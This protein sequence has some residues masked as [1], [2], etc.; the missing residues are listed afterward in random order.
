[1]ELLT[2]LFHE[3]PKSRIFNFHEYFNQSKI[4]LFVYLLLSFLSLIKSKFIHSIKATKIWKNIPICFDVT[5]HFQK[6]G[7]FL[8][9][10][11]CMNFKNLKKTSG[12]GIC[13]TIWWAATKQKSCC[14]ER[15]NCKYNQCNMR[16]FYESDTLDLH[17]RAVGRSGNPW[18]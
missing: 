15:S 13:E 8:A 12:L 11:E 1:M 18:G 14:I 4:D 6:I 3:F 7:W 2:T 9:F 16:G 10:S 17:G 5:N